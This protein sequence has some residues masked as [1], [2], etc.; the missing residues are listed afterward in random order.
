MK[1]AILF[2]T[3]VFLLTFGACD[4]R[5][6]PAERSGKEIDEAVDKVRDSAKSA[7]EDVKEGAERAVDSAREVIVGTPKP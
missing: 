6:G 2:S 1:R 4:N 5:E 3:A 7:A